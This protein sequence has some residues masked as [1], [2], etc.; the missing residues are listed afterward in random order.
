M[1]DILKYRSNRSQHTCSGRELDWARSIL[2]NDFTSDWC[3]QF[4]DT[5]Y[6]KE[7]YFP[8]KDRKTAEKVSFIDSLNLKNSDKKLIEELEIVIISANKEITRWL[9]SINSNVALIR[10]DRYLYG[11]ANDYTETIKLLNNLKNRLKS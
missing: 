10:P 5:V 7:G 3:E 2:F 8:P 1:I 11:V 9:Y 6:A 4:S